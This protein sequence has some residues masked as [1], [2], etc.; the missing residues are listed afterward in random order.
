MTN[1]DMPSL[2]FP[3]HHTIS[4]CL[5]ITSS[6]SSSITS[7][8]FILSLYTHNIA[9]LLFV[10]LCRLEE[11]NLLYVKFLINEKMKGKNT[12]VGQDPRG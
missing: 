8:I 10:S 9:I 4:H 12:S 5:R 11:H 1:L 7:S 2:I 3:L 6:P